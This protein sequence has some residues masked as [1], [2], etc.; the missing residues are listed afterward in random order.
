[1]LNHRVFSA[2]WLLLLTAAVVSTGCLQSDNITTVAQ[3]PPQINQ[4][5][6]Y[7]IYQR[8]G[9]LSGLEDMLCIYDG[10]GCE[11]NS[12]GGRTHR[13]QVIALKLCK[14]EQAFEEAGFFTLPDEYPGNSQADAIRYSIDYAASGKKH[15]VTAYSNSMPDPLIPLIRELDQCVML[16]SLAGYR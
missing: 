7:I 10:G 1:M 15:R 2:G 9:G 4:G 6:P 5:D 14:M 11:L 16:V 12:K 13:C 8:S 3:L